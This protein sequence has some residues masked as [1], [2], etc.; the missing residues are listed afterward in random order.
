VT[1]AFRGFQGRS[2]EIQLDLGS[3]L[4]EALCERFDAVFNHTTLEHVFEVRTAVENLARMTRDLLILVVPFAQVQ[5]EKEGAYEDYWRFSPT[6][7]RRLLGEN[8][9]EVVYESAND[10][11]NAAV[12]LFVV[13][14]RHPERW[15]GRVPEG[16]A[17]YPAGDWIGRPEEPGARRGNRLSRRLRRLWRDLTRFARRRA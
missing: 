13:G 17:V 9:L 4:P 12:Y 8:G 14:S 5:H 2:G 10:D 3:P 1:G 7:M 15:R 6:C 16:P 11:V